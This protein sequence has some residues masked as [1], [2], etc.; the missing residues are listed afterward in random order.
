MSK[1]SVFLFIFFISSTLAQEK[2]TPQQKEERCKKELEEKCDPN[3][4][5]HTC[6]MDGIKAKEKKFSKDCAMVYI[7]Q[8]Q[9]G[10]HPNPCIAE[11]EALCPKDYT[12]K[13]IRA[14]INS[15]SSECQEAVTADGIP[16]TEYDEEAKKIVSEC[17]TGLTVACDYL[18]IE[19]EM[20]FKGGKYDKGMDIN[21][22]FTNC[23]QNYMRKPTDEKCDT[24]MK[25]FQEQF[26][27]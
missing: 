6:I 15:L 26:K 10:A 13:C 12:G 7:G 8:M 16:K 22:Q 20:A 3:L 24:S 1:I 17:E 23:V 25:E 18:N 27:K 21:K 5:T 2:E 11:R 9:K 14:Q 4:A 19:A